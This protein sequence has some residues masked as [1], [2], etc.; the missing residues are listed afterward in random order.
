MAS[1]SG[2]HLDDPARTALWRRA[3]LQKGAAVAS[4]LE[5]LLAGKEVDLGS[6]VAPGKASADPELRL[7]A[8]LERIDRSIKGGIGRCRV[9]TAPLPAASLDE[10]PWLDRCAAHPEPT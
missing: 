8:F 6:L 10:T 4:A 1:L 5:A 7:R 2:A 9:C 3:L